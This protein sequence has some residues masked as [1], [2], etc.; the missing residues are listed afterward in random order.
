MK[1]KNPKIEKLYKH[2]SQISKEAYK[3]HFLISNIIFSKQGT[4]NQLLENYLSEDPPPKISFQL[5]IKKL[6]LYLVKNLIGWAFSIIASIFH[7]ISGQKFELGKEED[8]LI[9]VDTYFIVTQILEKGEIKDIY[10]PKLS[11]HLTKRKKKFA[12]TPRWFGSKKPLGLFK[13]FKVIKEKRIPVLTQ[14]QVLTLSDYIRS[15]IFLFL[16][17]FSVFRI[18]NRLG[19]SYEDKLVS[20]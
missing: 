1:F 3:D 8:E 10:F 12:Y 2:L 19:S 6:F 9:L 15:L 18:M 14:Y 5:I 13:I 20:Y 4:S 17:P 16:Y 7:T 11:E